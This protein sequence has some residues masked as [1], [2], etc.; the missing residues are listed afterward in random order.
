LS[1]I[2]FIPCGRFACLVESVY[3]IGMGCGYD[4]P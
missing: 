1:K 4:Q 3:Q 2:S